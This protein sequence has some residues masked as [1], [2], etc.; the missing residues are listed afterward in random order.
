MVFF[1]SLSTEI[2][3]GQAEVF[4]FPWKN[5]RFSDTGNAGNWLFFCKYN[6]IL[7]CVTW[8]FASHIC[9]FSMIANCWSFPLQYGS[10]FKYFKSTTGNFQPWKG[11]GM[12]IVV[13]SGKQLLK[14][15][16]LPSRFQ[17]K[18]FMIWRFAQLKWRSKYTITADVVTLRSYSWTLH[19]LDMLIFCIFLIVCMSHY[20]QDNLSSM[21]LVTLCWKCTNFICY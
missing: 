14:I 21:A 8:M 1:S 15:F 7:C 13:W 18:K 4:W 2:Y 9:M 11:P 3:Q 20:N 12:H 16:W 6:F 17:L 19:M 10:C 5:N